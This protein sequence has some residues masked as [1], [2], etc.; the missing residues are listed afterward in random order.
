MGEDYAVNETPESPIR[1][2]CLRRFQT[3][4][5]KVFLGNGTPSHE[6]RITAAETQLRTIVWLLRSVLG[7]VLANLASL[8]F[9]L[10]RRGI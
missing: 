9:L 8:L 5:G 2:E 3:L 10:L 7:I 1:G 4:E 6:S